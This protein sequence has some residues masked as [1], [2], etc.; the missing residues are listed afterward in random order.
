MAVP[1]PLVYWPLTIGATNNLVPFY[2]G[3]NLTATIAS[4]VYYTPEDFIDAVVAALNAADF[5]NGY[6]AG[7]I[8]SEGRS[9]IQAGVN[10]FYFRFGDA[11]TNAAY[12]HLGHY[13]SNTSSGL[14]HVSPRQMSNMFLSPV[15][16]REDTEPLYERPNTITTIALGGYSRTFDE[17]AVL[18]TRVVTF[19]YLDPGYTRIIHEDASTSQRAIENWWRNG[20]ARFRYWSD[21]DTREDPGDYF[22]DNETVQNGFKPTRPKNKAIYKVTFKMRR[23]VP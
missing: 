5:G 14:S 16:V 7:N 10:P 21:E 23:F 1:K 19:D 18:E 20:Y 11:P 13:A 4:G 12:A 9:D 17:G 3:S 2:R 15:A 22:L 6:T 8:D